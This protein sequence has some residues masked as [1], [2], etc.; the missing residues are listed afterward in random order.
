MLHYFLKKHTSYAQYL[1]DLFVEIVFFTSSNNGYFIDIGAYDGI[2][3]SNSYFFEK[4]KL[5][6]GVAIEPNEKIFV[7]L[8][9]NRTCN[10]VNGVITNIDGELDYLRVDGD[11]EMLSGIINNF[12]EKHK[13]R[14]ENNTETYGGTTVVEKVKSYSINSLINQHQIYAIDLLSIDTEGSELQ[15]LSD[16]PFDKVIPRIILVE[17]NY[18]TNEF[19]IF[20]KD[21]GYSFCFRLGDDIFCRDKICL[22]IK[23]KIWIFRIIK[24]LK[25]YKIGY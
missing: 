10:L 2:K 7:K 8:Q 1:Q 19:S 18:R 12:D 16:F 23:M 11:G 4:H 20:L 21:K 3:F 13:Q 22:S 9:Q 14:I 25:W 15:I 17:N 6:K 24:K 5:W